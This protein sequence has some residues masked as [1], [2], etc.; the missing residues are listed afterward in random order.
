MIHE[1]IPWRTL[2]RFSI[3]PLKVARR[4][5]E[6]GEITIPVGAT[7][8]PELF[9]LNIRKERLRQFYEQRRLEPLE[10]TKGSRQYYRD[11]QARLRGEIVTPLAPVAS[12]IVASLPATR[13]PIAAKQ[14]KPKPKGARR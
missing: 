1:L 8:D 13:V 9:P 14:G 11:Q 6:I 2:T 4:P 7:L 3:P 5:L 10:G 12:Q